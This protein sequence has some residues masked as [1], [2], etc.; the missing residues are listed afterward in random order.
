MKIIRTFD[1]PIPESIARERVAAFCRKSSYRQ[2]SDSDGMVHYKRGSLS[3][4]LFS[5][6]PTCWPCTVNVY[7]MSETGSAKVKIEA[8]ISTDPA[9]SSFGAELL[10]AE[11]NLLESAVNTNEIKSYD[12]GDLKKR[13]AA[14]VFYIVRVFASFLFS[15]I[16]GIFAGLFA[17]IKL[18]LTILSASAIGA[19]VLLVFGGLLLAFWGRREKN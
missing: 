15:V 9:E 1:I 11:L 17:Y 5:F 12:V 8:E 13:V 14:Y 19:G 10:T 16:L 7:I 6:N 3:G 2:L 4:A 18:N